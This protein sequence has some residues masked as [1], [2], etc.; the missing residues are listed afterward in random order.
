MEQP[1]SL[2]ETPTAPLMKHRLIAVLWALSGGLFAVGAAFLKEFTSGGALLMAAVVEEILKPVG[3]YYL[4][5]RRR[6]YLSSRLNVALLSTL[7]GIVFAAIENVVYLK[8]Y[9]PDPEPRLVLYRWTVCVAVH[10]V[11]SFI[12]GLGLG[13]LLGRFNRGEP[14]ELEA[15]IKWI[16]AAVVLHAGYNTVVIFFHVAG[17]RLY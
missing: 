3:V 10:A 11:C 2:P 4:L 8:V 9:F 13:N 1:S 12:M 14:F 17:W 16:A 6:H 7:G 15:C 5:R